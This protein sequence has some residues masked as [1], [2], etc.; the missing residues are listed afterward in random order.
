[1]KAPGYTWRIKIEPAEIDDF[2]MIT[3]EIGLNR[4]HVDA[5]IDDPTLEIDIEDE[6]TT[7]VRTAYRLYAKPADVNMERDYGLSAEDLERL[8]GTAA[9]S[10]GPSGGPSGGGAGGAGEGDGAAGGASDVGGMADLL[11]MATELG[12]DPM[13]F[14]FLL[15]PNGFDPRELSLLP[16]ED[17]MQLVTLMEAVFSQGSEAALGPASQLTGESLRDLARGARAGRGG[18]RG[19]RSEAG[20][21]SRGDRRRGDRRRGERDA[22]GRSD[23]RGG[24]GSGRGRSEARDR[25]DRGRGADRDLRDR[26]GRDEDR[27]APTGRGRERTGR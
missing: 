19:R 6:G 17:F 16:E 23:R 12:I 9:E 18:A 25:R 26:P 27:R 21:R 5:Q 13:M 7:I 24:E 4:D 14:D 2:Y 11:G 10:A 20:A 22:G 3:I 15:D 1:V 8:M